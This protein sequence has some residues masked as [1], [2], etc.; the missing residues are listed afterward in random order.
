M[1][2]LRSGASV[3]L[4]TGFAATV[5][6]GVSFSA[7]GSVTPADAATGSLPSNGVFLNAADTPNWHISAFGYD[8]LHAEGY[9]GKGVTIAIAEADFD[10]TF[11]DLEGANIEYIPLPDKC[12]DPNLEPKYKNHGS[13]VASTI[14]GQGGQG[15]VQGIAPDAKLLVYQASTGYNQQDDDCAGAKAGVGA[16]VYYAAEAGADVVSVSFG[17]VD[18]PDTGYLAMRDIPLFEAAGNRGDSVAGITPASI[19]VGAY[20]ATGAVPEWSANSPDVSLV[21]PGGSLYMRAA[22]A[23]GQLEPVDGT[24]FA[25]PIAAATLALGKQKYPEAGGHQL[26]QSLA[27]N[28][29]GGNPELKHLDDKQGAGKVDALAFMA[30]DPTQY[31]EE[32]PFL[33]KVNDNSDDDLRG[34]EDSLNGMRLSPGDDL[35]DYK[36]NAGPNPAVIKW[37]PD[38]KAQFLGSGPDAD[39]WE[40][41]GNSNS[42][43]NNGEESHSE[44]LSQAENS[45]NGMRTVIIAVIAGVALLAIL[46]TV[47]AVVARRKSA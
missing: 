32:P 34:V 35:K 25:A 47:V 10:P 30:A 31:P 2:R 15:R 29:V 44:G 18:A 38:E 12:V 5:L 1:K 46:V 23:N 36:E 24:S 28:T 7:T 8:K 19:G 37:L 39:Y 45:V 20:D 26:V 13:M 4:L 11:P 21:A 22:G 27:R 16:R 17:T 40:Q 33:T 6:A 42:N 14:V 43:L 3:R 9:T 41:H